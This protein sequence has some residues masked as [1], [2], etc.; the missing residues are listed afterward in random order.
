ML[1][2]IARL[3]KDGGKDIEQAMK[4]AIED[5][6]RRA[7]QLKDCKFEGSTAVVV[8]LH[9]DKWVA[10]NVGDCRAVLSRG[11]GH[12]VNLTTDHKPYF[13]AERARIEKA[14]GKVVAEG[15]MD[16]NGYPIPGYG[17]CR[18]NGG[19]GVA[20][21]LGY[22]FDR[23]ALSPEP[24]L[25]MTAVTED[26]VFVLLASDGVWDV[27]TSQDA[28]ALVHEGMDKGDVNKEDIAELVVK[29]ALSQHAFDNLTV[30]IMWVK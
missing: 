4:N 23:P 21:T 25:S 19:I 11:V 3:S 14:G 28:V 2:E 27:M 22:E 18:V 8:K 15:K 17:I 13:P 9:Q 10:A 30:V 16:E 1:P 7:L 24:E 6:D 26:D 20:R 29:K 12:A 5:I